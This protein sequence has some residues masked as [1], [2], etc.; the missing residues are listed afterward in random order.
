MSIS[1]KKVIPLSIDCQAFKPKREKEMEK[2][3]SLDI[4][5]IE[6]E[7]QNIKLTDIPIRK[8]SADSTTVSK[9]EE[10]SELYSSI[11]SPIES[12]K[13]EPQNELFFGRDRNCS[14]SVSNFYHLTEENIRETYPECFNYQKTKNY[15][16]KEKFFN[17]NVSEQKNIANTISLNNNEYSNILADNSFHPIQMTT[18]FPINQQMFYEGQGKFDLP[19]Y[20]F[21]YYGWDGKLLIYI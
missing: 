7:E 10:P 17:K 5:H 20:Y 11:N 15:I 8:S 4:N 19:I 3:L 18:V 14:N 9:T 13:N 2:K 6:E 12:P 1:E 21:G 16:N